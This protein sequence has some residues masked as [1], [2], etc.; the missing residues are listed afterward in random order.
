MAPPL[1]YVRHQGAVWMLS[2]GN[3]NAESQRA[4]RFAENFF[5]GCPLRGSSRNTP[6]TSLCDP[7][8]SLRLCVGVPGL[9]LS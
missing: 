9:R 6:K 7:L 3:P 4:Q 8:R 1:F 2:L 5:W